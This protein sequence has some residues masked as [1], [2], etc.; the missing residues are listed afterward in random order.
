MEF[1]NAIAKVRFAS[2]KPQRVQL[3]K[4]PDLLAELLCLEPGQKV[5]VDGGQWLYYVI[6]GNAAITDGKTTT[7]LSAG[8]FA[9]SEDHRHAIASADDRRLIVLAATA[10]K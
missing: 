5:Q 10:V 6:T 8:R 4:G 3:H 2:A 7:Q 1:V 9:A